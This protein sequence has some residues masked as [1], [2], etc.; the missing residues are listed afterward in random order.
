MAFDPLLLYRLAAELLEC[1][2]AEV[3]RLPLFDPT[4]LA[5][6]ERVVVWPG[7]PSYE[8]CAGGEMYAYVERTY[9]TTPDGFPGQLASIDT[10]RAPSVALAIVVGI[11]RCQPLGDDHGNPPSTGALDK[12]ARQVYADMHAVWRGVMCCI[13]AP[14]WDDEIDVLLADHR[15][16]QPQTV[17]GSEL[18]LTLGPPDRCVCPPAPDPGP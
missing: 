17:V 5:A 1:G 15:V 4:L 16:I 8:L 9:P 14:E 10:C 7:Q 3:A 12:S 6:P 2:R 11:I 18:R 13:A